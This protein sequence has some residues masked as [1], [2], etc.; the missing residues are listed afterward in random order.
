[1]ERI[2]QLDGL[3]AMAILMVFATHAFH[4]PLL[5]TGVDLFFVLSGYLIT[6]ILL[7]LKE[8]REQRGY[9]IPFYWRRACRILPPYAV[10][11][12]VIGCTFAV[13][14]RHLWYWY[15]FFMA[16]MVV[17]FHKGGIDAMTPLWSLAVEEQFYLFWPWVVLFCRKRTIIRIAAGAI[18]ICPI[19]RALATPF[20]TNHFPIYCLT[21]FRTDAL[22][23]G[24][25]VAVSELQDP[26]W[27]AG[28][29]RLAAGVSCAAFA[30]LGILSFLPSFRTG[31]NSVVFNTVGYSLSTLFFGG[32]LV[33][34]LG[35]RGGL[36]Q[37]LLSWA[38]ARYLGRISYTFYLYHLAVFIKIEQYVHVRFLNQAVSFAITFILADLS[39]RFMESPILRRRTQKEK[40]SLA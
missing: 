9:W 16:N 5:W 17:A 22:A 30:L 2:P 31:A 33:F 10:F 39:W 11:L 14:W 38:P 24:A 34:V 35:M 18:L 37:N 15:A 12:V 8:Q 40:A 6:R 36:L 19:L 1:M 32:T 26:G 29:R 25:F 21:P 20:F 23:M 7:G 28:K 27:I 3:R 13:D 4:A